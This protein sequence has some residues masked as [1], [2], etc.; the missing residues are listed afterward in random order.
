MFYEIASLLGITMTEMQI[1]FIG[2][3]VISTSIVQ[4]SVVLQGGSLDD[5][6]SHL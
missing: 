6:Y 4:M 3:L 2:Q 5:P 1:V